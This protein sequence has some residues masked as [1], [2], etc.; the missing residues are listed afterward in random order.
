MDDN[1]KLESLESHIERLDM[2]IY[3]NSR[4]KVNGSGIVGETRTLRREFDEFRDSMKQH[5]GLVNL[6]TVGIVV[7]WR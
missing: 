1:M 7:F 4:E 2:T 6:V 3:G 5:G